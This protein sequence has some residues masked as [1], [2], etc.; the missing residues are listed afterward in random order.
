MVFYENFIVIQPEESTS[1]KGLPYFW[2]LSMCEAIRQQRPDTELLLMGF[3]KGAWWG[4]LFLA[5][6]PTLFHGA[7]LLAGYCSPMQLPDEREQEGS[8]VAMAAAARV[9]RVHAVLGALDAAAPI[10]AGVYNR[11]ALGTS[12]G[13]ACLAAATED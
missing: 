6:K 11:I 12:Q 9:S 13:N 8:E 2:L 5:T 10:H 3:S 7:V 4:G 1:W